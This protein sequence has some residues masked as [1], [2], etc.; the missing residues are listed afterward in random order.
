MIKARTR[1]LPYPFMTTII[2][3]MLVVFISLYIFTVS[4]APCRITLLNNIPI[5]VIWTLFFCVS[6]I[7]HLVVII[8]RLLVVIKINESGISKSFL[9]RFLKANISWNEIAEVRYFLYVSEQIV[10]SKSRELA[11]IPLLKWH[12]LK[13]IIFMGLSK[14]R[15]AIMKQYLQQPIV[16]MPDKVKAR[17]EQKIN[18]N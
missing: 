7:I 18:N 8:P 1:F 9:G 4:Y 15:Y 3:I 2:L 5:F 6:S 12:K 17:L 16:G 13:D 14:K 10:F 11:S